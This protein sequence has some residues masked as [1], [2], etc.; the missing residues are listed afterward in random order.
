MIVS[1]FYPTA[2]VV[3]VWLGVFVQCAARSHCR[4]AAPRLALAMTTEL[5]EKAKPALGFE[6]KISAD[7]LGFG[8]TG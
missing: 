1:I 8:L 5:F 3:G 6:L 2:M 7:G 4:V